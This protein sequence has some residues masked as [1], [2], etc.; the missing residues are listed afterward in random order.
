MELVE[1]FVGV[2]MFMVEDELVDFEVSEPFETYGEAVGF[3]D[4]C[5]SS[6][7][8]AYGNVEKRFVKGEAQQS[9][10]DDEQ[11]EG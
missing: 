8:F 1:R 3:I 11:G 2:V 7:E 6:P 10:R 9:E 5:K 4:G